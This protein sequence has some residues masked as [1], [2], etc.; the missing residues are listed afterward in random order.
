MPKKEQGLNKIDMSEIMEKIGLDMKKSTERAT[1]LKERILKHLKKIKAGSVTIIYEGSGD[2]GSV[3]EVR[4]FDKEGKQ[5]ELSEDPAILVE[6]RHTRF[7]NGN[8][9]N[10]TEEKEVDL[11][12]ALEELAYDALA[13]HHPGWEINEGSYGELNIN[14]KDGTATLQH[15]TIIQET[16]YSETEL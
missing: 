3:E 8:W 16:E 15:N 9:E 1:S 14:V 2:S 13:G 10:V 7:S 6:L 4:V 11:E 12:D 5:L